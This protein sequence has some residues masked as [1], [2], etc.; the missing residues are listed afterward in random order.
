MLGEAFSI[1]FLDFFVAFMAG[2]IVIPSCFAYGIEAG[3]GPGL[4]FQTLPNIFN[5]MAGGRVWGSL[6]F[7]FMVFAALSTVI[8]VF[9][10]II[11]FGMDLWGWSRKKA[12]LINVFVVIILSLPAAL[13]YNLLS[14]IQPLGA[15]TT[16]LDLEDFVISNNILPLG[17]LI[18][19]LFCCSK[20]YGWGWDNFIKEVN[21]GEGMSF[22]KA[23]RIYVKYILPIILIWIWAQGYISKFFA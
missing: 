6:F 18:Y 16:I 4:V 10:N 9:E 20:K 5:S 13:G 8:A 12:C 7:L 22:P 3:Q 21:T 1:A 17:S 15:G 19:V 11:S 14:G 23:I 2:L